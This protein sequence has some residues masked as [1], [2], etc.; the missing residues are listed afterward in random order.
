MTVSGGANLFHHTST[1]TQHTQKQA[2]ICLSL[3]QGREIS[4]LTIIYHLYREDPDK[5]SIVILYIAES[6]SQL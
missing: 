1:T 2:D 3:L 4:N 5:V 6:V